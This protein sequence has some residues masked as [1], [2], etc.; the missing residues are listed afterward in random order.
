MGASRVWSAI[1]TGELQGGLAKYHYRRNPAHFFGG[2]AF[3]ILINAMWVFCSYA[4]IV[5]G[6]LPE[7]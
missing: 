4:V 1:R 7:L 3:W 5:Y 2:I 6:L